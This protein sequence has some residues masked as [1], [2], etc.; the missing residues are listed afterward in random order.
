MKSPEMKIEK[1]NHWQNEPDDY[2]YDDYDSYGHGEYA[3]YD[4]Y[5]DYEN[6]DYGHEAYQPSRSRAAQNT[7]SSRSRK[8]KSSGQHRRW[9]KKQRFF[10]SQNVNSSEKL[11]KINHT[12]YKEEKRK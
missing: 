4:D 3:D 11:F 1:R 2:G 12:R 5:D 7:R 8:R 6:E 9:A 10:N